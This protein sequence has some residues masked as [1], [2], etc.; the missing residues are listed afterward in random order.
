MVAELGSKSRKKLTLL[1]ALLLGVVIAALWIWPQ[2]DP[3]HDGKRISEWMHE[4]EMDRAGTQSEAHHALCEAGTVAAPRLLAGLHAKDDSKFYTSLWPKL[5][6]FLRRRLPPPRTH[7]VF[8]YCCAS[9]LGY[10]E[11]SSPQIIREL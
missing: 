9:V 2:A 11:P 3:V 8:R 4:L 5:P 1:S 7:R 10:I 6:A